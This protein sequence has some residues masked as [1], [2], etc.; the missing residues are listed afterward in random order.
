MTPAL[1]TLLNTLV[2]IVSLPLSV[3]L[4]ANLLG[5][6]DQRPITKPLTRLIITC[7]G[8]S[9]FLVLTHRSFGLPIALAF[10][11]VTLCHAVAGFAFRRYG[12]G[13]EVVKKGLGERNWGGEGEP[14]TEALSKDENITIPPSP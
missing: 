4:L 3:W 7:A 2:F 12:L 14:V 6:L 9:A 5:L 8:I 1:F 10:T 13:I 11:I